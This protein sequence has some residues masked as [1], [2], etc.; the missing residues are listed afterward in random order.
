[1]QL[2]NVFNNTVIFTAQETIYI[3]S[4]SELQLQL[5]RATL[6]CACCCCLEYFNLVKANYMRKISPTRERDHSREILKIV[7]IFLT[8]TAACS[9]FVNLAKI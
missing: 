2:E 8:S 9:I 1:M 6:V 7:K 3:R 4:L 5:P